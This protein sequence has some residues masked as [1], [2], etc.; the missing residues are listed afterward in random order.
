M[1]H[2]ELPGGFAALVALAEET[3]DVIGQWIEPLPMTRKVEAEL[4]A[5]IS[6][7]IYARRA[8]NATRD[9]ADRSETARRLLPSATRLRERTEQQ[10]RRRLTLA[11]TRTGLPVQQSDLVLTSVK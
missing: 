3:A 5:A 11:I 1:K 7:A 6:A 4:R 8:F 10:L 9:A 2:T